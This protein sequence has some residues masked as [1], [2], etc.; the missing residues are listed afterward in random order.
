MLAQHGLNATSIR[1]MSKR[2]GTPGLDLPPLPRRQAA[3][4]RPGS[5]VGGRACRT[6]AGGAAAGRPASGRGRVHGGMAG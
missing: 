3:G 1:E 4:D 5:G 2:A 6:A